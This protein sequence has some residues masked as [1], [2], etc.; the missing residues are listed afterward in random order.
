MKARVINTVPEMYEKGPKKIHKSEIKMH[1][2]FVVR[3]TKVVQKAF[4]NI[5]PL[6]LTGSSTNQKKVEISQNF[7]AFSEYM[8]FNILDKIQNFRPQ[9]LAGT[10]RAPAILYAHNIDETFWGR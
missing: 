7:V 8:N 4:Q 3:P 2:I 1:C 6:F 5:S 10:M 9:W